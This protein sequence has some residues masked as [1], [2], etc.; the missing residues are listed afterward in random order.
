MELFHLEAILDWLMQSVPCVSVFT[1]RDKE[2]RTT[3]RTSL[4]YSV[5]PL[6]TVPT[7]H[8]DEAKTARKKNRQLSN[9][10]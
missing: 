4:R 1:L 10:P 9:S 5:K 6:C 7:R 3:Y 2:E 8:K